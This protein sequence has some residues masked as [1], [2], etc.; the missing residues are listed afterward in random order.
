M[1]TFTSFKRMIALMSINA[2]DGRIIIFT[3]KS[4]LSFKGEGVAASAS[5]PMLF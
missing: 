2:N 4:N 1:Q 5:I 3:E